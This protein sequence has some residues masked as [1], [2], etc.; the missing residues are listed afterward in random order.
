MGH[1]RQLHLDGHCPLLQLIVGRLGVLLFF[2]EP[3]TFLL[4]RLAL[5]SILGLAN[6]WT[7]LVC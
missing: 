4:Q 6:L 3:A 1:V 7:D 2:T 5:R